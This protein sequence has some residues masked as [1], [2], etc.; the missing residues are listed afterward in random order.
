MLRLLDNTTPI[1]LTLK[2]GFH[3]GVAV[4]AVGGEGGAAAEYE[5]VLLLLQVGEP[6]A[7]RGLQAQLTTLVSSYRVAM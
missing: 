1:V 7:G 5:T 2:A 3:A 4:G 6:G